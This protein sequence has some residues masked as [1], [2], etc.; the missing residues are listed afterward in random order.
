MATIN[1]PFL[2][3]P[4][5]S[6]AK[7][8][9]WPIRL[10]AGTREV[11][12]RLDRLE[13]RMTYLEERVDS[14]IQLVLLLFAKMAPEW[15]STELAQVLPQVA[16]LGPV[17]QA[18]DRMR[19]AGNPIS[20]AEIDRLNIKRASL[21]D[22]RRRMLDANPGDLGPLIYLREAIAQTDRALLAAEMERLRDSHQF[23]GNTLEEQLGTD[24]WIL[25]AGGG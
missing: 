12:R 2:Q 20:T 3:V 16:A 25:R 1:F 18:F 17:D 19:S 5:R 14:L 22:K 21:V 15:T 11:E 10:A 9:A 8:I 6:F 4:L 24:R 7:L 13:E 23:N